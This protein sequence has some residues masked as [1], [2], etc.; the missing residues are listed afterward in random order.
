MG[1]KLTFEGSVFLHDASLA[2]ITKYTKEPVVVAF[3]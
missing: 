1:Q 2:V 3:D